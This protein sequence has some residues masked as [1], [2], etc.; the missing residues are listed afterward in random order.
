MKIFWSWQSD[1]PGEIGRY[2]IRDALKDAIKKLKQGEEVE[3]AI[4]ENLHLDQDIQGKTGSPELARTIFNKITHAELVVA[5]VTIVGKTDIGEPLVNSNVSIELGYALHACTD[6]RLLMVFNEHYGTYEQL[7]FDLRHRGGAVVFKIAPGA[8]PQQITDTCKLLTDAFVRK[9]KPF[10][11]VP[12][13]IK[14]PLSLKPIIETHLQRRYSLPNG[15]SDDVFQLRLSV[16]NDGETEAT[17]FTLQV[18]IPGELIDETPPLGVSRPGPPGFT[19][20]EM[21]HE[22]ARIKHLYPDTTSPPLI[23]FNVAVRDHTKRQPEAMKKALT[24]TVYSGSMKSKKRSLTIA[25][26]ADSVPK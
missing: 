6:D 5:D 20:F 12:P 9:L 13:R 11:Q 4:R 25:D 21:T 18:D 26:L 19:R 14:E 7:P 23:T 10:L 8:D 1:T 16:Q 24:A 15:G 22:N 3:E 17:D 2:L